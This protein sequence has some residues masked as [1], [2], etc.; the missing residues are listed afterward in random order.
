MTALGT[1]ETPPPLLPV[2]EMLAS[3][4]KIKLARALAAID[5]GG[6]SLEL[7]ILTPHRQLTTRKWAVISGKSIG[8]SGLISA[9]AR[10]VFLEAI[11]EA[12]TMLTSYGVRRQDILA[13]ATA[14]LRDAKN[15]EKMAELARYKG[16]PLRII[17]GKE[18]GRLIYISVLR[19]QRVPWN[20]PNLVVEIGGGSTELVPGTGADGVI[21]QHTMVLPMG[22]G[23]FNL[24]HPTDQKGLATIQDVVKTLLQEN[25]PLK[26]RPIMQGRPAFMKNASEITV[27]R[28]QVLEQTGTDIFREALT[29]NLIQETLTSQG[30][31][32]LQHENFPS[33]RAANKLV[34]K[35]AMLSVL[36]EYLDL[37]S[38][39]FGPDWGLKYGLLE[40]LL[41]RRARS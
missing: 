35:L 36:L 7:V 9:E 18:E 5:V 12:K 3:L 14:G 34:T 28:Q 17:R 20:R 37:D 11:E 40:K 26:S 21:V 10:T 8:E 30:R 39:R 6:N 4:P 16:I 23:R 33:L 25:I 32:T 22:T 31:F 38:I 15:G 41:K 13:V 24:A 2:E 27:F 29:L 1:L 19:G